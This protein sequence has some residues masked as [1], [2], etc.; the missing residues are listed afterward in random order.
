MVK[1]R[2]AGR[3]R[4]TGGPHAGRP[5][6]KTY[7]VTGA[8][9]GI[10]RGVALKLAALRANV[11]LAA[12]RTDVLE[13]VAAQMSA[14]GGTPLVVTTDVSRPDDMRRLAQA[15]LA[16]FERID[17]WINNAGAGAIGRFEEIP[18]EDHA[19]VAD[20]NL[21]GVISSLNPREEVPVG[22]KARGALAGHWLTPDL[23]ER[24]SANVAHKYQYEL[25]PPAPPTGGSVQQP[26]APGTGADG[27]LRQRIQREDAARE[28]E[29]G[30]PAKQ[31][32]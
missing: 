19:R 16:R 23:A 1:R 31:G 32:N 2:G 26:M 30:K 25:A 18:I 22:W 28:S 20:V 12:R 15:T 14:A 17:V 29:R 13:A 8:S 6:S 5:H 11:V 3:V 10:G 27:G 24:I 7:V 9:S 4:P 21:K